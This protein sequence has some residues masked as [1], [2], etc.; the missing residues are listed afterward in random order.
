MGAEP[1]RVT[2]A[3]FVCIGCALTAGACW[4]QAA[5]ADE[6]EARPVWTRPASQTEI[7]IAVSEDGIEFRDVEG[8][9][10]RGAA[11]PSMIR[12][13]GGDLL[14][15]SDYAVS[16]TP[17]DGT[18]PAVTRSG[19]RGR[20]WSALMPVALVSPSESLVRPRHAELIG[21]DRG[22]VRM[23]IA[24]DRAR[25]PSGSDGDAL[26][27][28]AASSRDGVRF[29]I[30]SAACTRP[31]DAADA[32]P[33]VSVLEREMRLY[34]QSPPRRTD[35]DPTPAPVVGYRRA[36]GATFAPEAERV[37]IDADFVGSV[38][39][40]AGMLRAYVS[41]DEGV[42]SFRSKEGRLWL[43]EEGVR[44]AG[45]WDPAAVTLRDG[46]VVMLYCAPR[47]PVKRGAP[48][49]VSIDDAGFRE[50]LREAEDA[51]KIADARHREFSATDEVAVQGGDAAAPGADDAWADVDPDGEIGAYGFAGHD[52]VDASL[53]VASAA[54]GVSFDEDGFAP[55]PDFI[56]PI[57]YAAHYRALLGP[58]HDDAYP[59]YADL[60]MDPADEFSLR[61]DWPEF[62]D[63]FNG[64]VHEG[65][66]VPWSD[67]D[68]PDWTDTSEAVAHLLEG[69]REATRHAG[70]A[71]PLRFVDEDLEQFDG[72]ALLFAMRLPQ[73][74]G[75]RALVKATLADAWRVD[76]DGRV[77]PE[78][79]RDAIET[80][81][82]GAGHMAQGRTIIED[83]VGIAERALTQE[84]ARQA[85]H[86][87]VFSTEEEIAA[88]LEVLLAHDRDDRD[89]T[90]SLRGEHMA[91][92]DAIQALFPPSPE[93]GDPAIDI[94]LA[95]KLSGMTGGGEGDALARMT[96]AD[97]RESVRVF[98][99]HYHEMAEMWRT[100][101]PEVRAADIGEIEERN[102]YAT[103]LTRAFMPSLSRYY[104]LAARE[105]AS[106]RATKLAYAIHLYEKQTGRWPESLDEL[107]AS[108][109]ASVRTDPFTGTDFGYRVDETGPRIYSLSEDG[110]D[111]GGIHARRW[112]DDP[113]DGSDDHVFWPPQP[114]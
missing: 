13:P 22:F 53:D 79:M 99:E 20:T 93:G 78:R 39:A 51:Q 9:L 14:V 114:R 16:Q 32:H 66:P 24:H 96:A 62:V 73:L 109:G 110:I 52:G 59:Y 80:S 36:G 113:V 6:R 40:T 94:E 54:D 91:S 72:K 37:A 44:V 85:L 31:I 88:T 106:R 43:R 47:S 69:F 12:L 84:T 112:A 17:H 42:V 100:G 90:L 2:F 27:I 105:R 5:S 65:P 48:S 11:A 19:D 87:G 58:V 56:Q 81:L 18:V 104:E 45:G 7:R 46:S 86:Q 33:V 30:D 67:E 49:L 25:G 63:M 64:G 8:V 95:E 35:G 15:V 10:L 74:A 108:Y 82:R 28:A 77:P 1:V 70:Y 75:H 76:E 107:P 89:P 50:R 3:G 61:P 4:A 21:P 29:R 97:G 41:T 57:D 92:M 23:L 83:L 38:V 26:L 71:T 103:P 34:V 101:Y 102:A 60:M 68:H 55:S 98:D 111:N